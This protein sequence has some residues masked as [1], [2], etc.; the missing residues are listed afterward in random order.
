MLDRIAFYINFIK[1][2]KV[3]NAFEKLDITEKAAYR[4]R[5]LNKIVR[6]AVR[7]SQFY[8]ELYKEININEDIRFEE[9]P[10]VNKKLIV[11]NFNAVVTKKGLEY[12][13]IGEYFQK[14]FSFNNRYKRKYLAFHTSGSTGAPSYVLW[15]PAEFGRATASFYYRM[16]RLVHKSF[17]FTNLLKK[18]RV[19]YIGILNDY[20]GGNSWAYAMKSFCSLKM[21]SAFQPLDS[22]CEEL[23]S[24]QPDV[25]MT[26]PTVLGE[27]A[28]RRRDKKLAI[29]PGTIIFAGEMIQPIDKEDINRYFSAAPHNS[30]STCETGP[31]AIQESTADELN[32][33]GDM[34]YVELLDDNNNVIKEC[35][36]IGRVVVTNLHNKV[37]PIIRYDI[38]DSAY[39]T[40]EGCFCKLSPI[41]GRNTSAFNFSSQQGELVKIPE[42]PFWTIH[43]KGVNRYQVIQQGSRELNIKIEWDE[44]LMESEGLSKAAIR[45][46]V[47]NKLAH[48]I[49]GYSKNL[50]INIQT[51]DVEKIIPN[52][53]GKIKITMPMNRQVP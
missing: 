33:Y 38:G 47:V 43:V 37:I 40:E 27:L 21:I 41:L 39:L 2:L 28:R 23:N 45:E 30:Y 1:Y 14:P 46:T 6:Y 11:D 10:L 5:A 24:F 34:V 19:A 15:N 7:H 35:N 29:K 17:S 16:S 22:I 20:V 32:V 4:E 51:E 13:S 25:I 18:S 26:K 52:K 8:R 3:I 53:N 42:F 48:M 9:I 44:R 12:E 49:E 50:M 31:V 36:K